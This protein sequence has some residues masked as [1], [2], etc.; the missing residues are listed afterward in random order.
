[1]KGFTVTVPIGNN[2]NAT[3]CK[4]GDIRLVGGKTTYEGRVEVCI[5][6]IWGTVCGFRWSTR[7][8]NV[9]CRQLG[10]IGLGR[11]K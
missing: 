6:R 7:N 4:T 11:Q 8:S 2:T 1:M 3:S 5:N 10:H 9:L